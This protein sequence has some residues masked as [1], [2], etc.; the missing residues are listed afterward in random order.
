MKVKDLKA[1][2]EGL[3]DDMLVVRSAFDHSYAPIWTVSEA[4]AETLNGEY[5]EC[6][7]NET[8]FDG[9]IISVLIVE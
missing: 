1:K 4:E 7:D 2:L 8:M 9:K 3:D 5:H 6:W